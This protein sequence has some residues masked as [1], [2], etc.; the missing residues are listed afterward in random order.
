MRSCGKVLVAKVV[1]DGCS[2][3]LHLPDY[4]DSSDSTSQL[5]ILADSKQAGQASGVEVERDVTEREA[6]LFLVAVAQNLLA[7]KKSLAAWPVNILV[8]LRRS[9]DKSLGV[10]M[11]VVGCTRWYRR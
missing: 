10:Y 11:W 6:N 8:T 7:S 4:R 3:A 9:I 2:S 5:G 1:G